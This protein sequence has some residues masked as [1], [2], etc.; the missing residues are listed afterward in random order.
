MVIQITRRHKIDLTFGGALLLFIVVAVF[1]FLGIRGLRDSQSGVQAT[2]AK[3]RRMALIPSKLKDA[4]SAQRGYLLTRQEV[5][6]SGYYP[7]PGTVTAEIQA[8]SEDMASDSAQAR[9]IERLRRLTSQKLTVMDIAI[10]AGRRG[11]FGGAAEFVRV[12]GGR[13]VMDSIAGLVAEMESH[14]FGLLQQRQARQNAAARWAILLI[15]VGGGLAILIVAGSRQSLVG[16]LRRR[17]TAELGCRSTM[18]RSVSLPYRF[19]AGAG[20]RPEARCLDRH[21]RPP[22]AHVHGGACR[23]RGRS[24]SG[25]SRSR[26][27]GLDRTG[28]YVSAGGHLL[29]RGNCP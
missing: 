12:A 3:L 22:A 17:E 6:L 29:L 26:S 25:R 4:E 8:M 27:V 13:E 14:E 16:E 28:R 11:D 2:E 23:H 19:L 18:K 5:F 15:S 10:E 21:G 9:R 24:V 20:G 7:I 1:S